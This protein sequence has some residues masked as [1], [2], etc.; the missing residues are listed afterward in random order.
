M[1]T[2][3]LS[4]KSGLP[5]PSSDFNAGR[6]I[7]EETQYQGDPQ[8]G[9]RSSP[10]PIKQEV[11]GGKVE[12]TGNYL[13]PA[14]QSSYTVYQGSPNYEQGPRG[15]EDEEMRRILEKYRGP[16]IGRTVVV[17]EELRK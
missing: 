8:F 5:P 9:Y 16:E 17:Q 7:F 14:Y 11:Q 10:Q 13:G 2:P 15:H 12:Y 6:P 4:K 1:F 3:F